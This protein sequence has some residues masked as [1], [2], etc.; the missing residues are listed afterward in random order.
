MDNSDSQQGMC[1]VFFLHK[2]GIDI[3]I[4]QRSFQKLII[5]LEYSAGTP[6]REDEPMAVRV[7]DIE[8]P[9]PHRFRVRG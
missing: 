6:P 5:P 1:Q 4:H 3:V 8:L 9:L 2:I 7:N